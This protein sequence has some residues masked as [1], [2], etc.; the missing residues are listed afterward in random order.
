MEKD[1]GSKAA[2]SSAKAGVAFTNAGRQPATEPVRAAAVP[3]TVLD[4]IGRTPTVALRRMTQ[5]GMAQILAKVESY[6]PGGSVKD[7]IALAMVEDAERRGLLQPGGTIVESTSGN[8]GIGLALVAAAKGYRCIITLPEGLSAERVFILRCFGAEVVMTPT[9]MGM[10][11]ANEKAEE[12]ASQIP[13]AFLA[14]Q[15]SNPANP[16][17]HRRT[18]AAEILEAT[19]GALDAFVAGIGTGGT[20]TGVGE[21]LREQV[22]RAKIIGVEPEASPLL[23][24]GYAGLH[25]IQGI[26]A[27]FV[28]AVLRREILDEVRTVS[29]EDAFRTMQRLAR[30]EGLLCGISSGAAVFVALQV[31]QELGPS[32]RVLTILPDTGER[33]MSME[34]AFQA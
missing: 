2:S 30:E 12:I 6:N 1:C 18:T 8:T 23:T 13:G 34:S 15:F 14:A 29:D 27:N 33:Y 7:R 4:L 25:R 28:P 11:G 22:P 19:G 17:V 5:P 31:A 26:G 10:T 16:E 21:V 32:A 20:I 9:E 24:R 3:R